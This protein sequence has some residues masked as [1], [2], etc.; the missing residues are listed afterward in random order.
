MGTLD[1]YN[2]NASLYA[3]DTLNADM[4]AMYSVF[5]KYVPQGRILD[6]GCG[7]GRDTKYFLGEGYKVTA[8]D[9]SEELCSYASAYTG[10]YVQC[11]LFG[12]ME[13]N[14]E[15]EGVWACSSLLHVPKGELN[16][17]FDKVAKALKPGGIFYVSFK[18][19][20][21]SGERNGRYFTDLNEDGLKE[22]LGE[23]PKFD[24]LETLITTDVRPGREN[25]KWLN[26][27][28]RKQ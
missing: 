27:L 15:F 22:V 3:S 21:F 6:L 26:A 25:E 17:I 4:S 2:K 18:Y 8:V 12:D 5:E 20:D 7:A 28:L 16:D 13:F 9:G 24:I 1:Y 10:I 19:G 23:E 14:G 11:M